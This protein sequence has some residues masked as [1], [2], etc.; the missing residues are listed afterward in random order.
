MSKLRIA[1][2]EPYETVQSLRSTAMATKEAVEILLGQ[3]GDGDDR[4]V[5]QGEMPP[6]LPRTY[7]DRWN[8]LAYLSGWKD[9]GAPYAPAGY[10]KL[11]SGLVIMRGLIMSGTAAPICTLPPG[12]RPAIQM[13]YVTITSPAAIA[14]LDLQQDGTL[15]Q[16]GG[17]SAWLSLNNVCFLAEG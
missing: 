17:S 8:P 14:R 10:R 6:D 11:P 13:L 1:I 7:D 5:T 16:S 12:Y 4:A 15:T 3:R 9:Y 2:P